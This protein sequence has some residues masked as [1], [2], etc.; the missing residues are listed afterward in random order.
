MASHTPR[1]GPRTGVDRTSPATGSRHVAPGP[2]YRR[3]YGL[4]L[5]REI[6]LVGSGLV[7]YRWVRWLVRDDVG[8]A[9]AN[10]RQVMNWEQ[11]L[12]IFTEADLQ[13]G[14]LDHD[15]VVW[16]L[17]RYYFLAHFT[18]AALLFAWL[19]ARHYEHYGRVRRVMFLTTFVGLA[20]HVGFPLAPPRWFPD[21]GFVDT[22]QT[23]GPR[24]YSSDAVASAANQIA[25]MPSL[26]V[27]WA[28]IG[29][30]AVVRF[31]SRRRLRWGAVAHPVMTTAGVVLTAN[32][33][34]LDVVA[35]V[36]LVAVA[37]LL[38]LPLQRRLERRCTPPSDAS[39]GAAA[40]GGV[41]PAPRRRDPVTLVG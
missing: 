1:G 13:A 38:D 23:F 28:I 11:A 35:A 33:W 8:E 20:L 39:A 25:A 24:I 7:L 31:S 22:L 10:A 26:H 12:G 40:A 34:W 29:A 32:H 41:P 17:N 21:A 14:I 18:V 30:W 36:A 5:G 37:S 19:F 6:L 16:V 2:W 3:R 15:G 9:L 4:P 27:A